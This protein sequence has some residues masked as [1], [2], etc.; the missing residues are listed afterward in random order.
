MFVA[1][2]KRL[3]SMRDSL[4]ACWVATLVDRHI[5][6]TIMNNSINFKCRVF[7]SC[8]FTSF[9]TSTLINSDINNDGAFKRHKNSHKKK[10]ETTKNSPTLT[11]RT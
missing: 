10:H 9:N 2:E 8:R 1:V 6:Y 11:Q 5:G 4:L 7:M 3:V